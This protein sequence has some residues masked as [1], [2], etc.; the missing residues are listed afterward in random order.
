M[1]GADGR[2]LGNRVF[3][4]EHLYR[5][6][7]G[8]APDLIVYFGDLAWRIMVIV[9]GDGLFTRENSTGPDDANHA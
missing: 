9:G 8:V 1:S 5:A 4:P 7:R 6:V 3:V 2:P